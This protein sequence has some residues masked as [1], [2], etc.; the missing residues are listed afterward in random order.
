MSHWWADPLK[1]KREIAVIRCNYTTSTAACTVTTTQQDF[2]ELFSKVYNTKD[3]Q[4]LNISNLIPIKL[5]NILSSIF[6]YKILWH[7][8]KSRKA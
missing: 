8:I 6:I 2:R 5:F 3:S 4:T 7:N 1:V